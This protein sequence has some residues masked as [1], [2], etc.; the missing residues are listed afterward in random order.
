MLDNKDPHEFLAEAETASQCKVG[1]QNGWELQDR[2]ALE[3][4]E[5]STS[6][7]ATYF[8]QQRLSHPI[9]F[10]SPKIF[11]QPRLSQGTTDHRPNHGY[12]V[13][14]PESKMYANDLDSLQ[15][16][17]H[18]GGWFSSKNKGYQHITHMKSQ[19]S[20]G[21]TK[22]KTSASGSLPFNYRNQQTVENLERPIGHFRLNK[23][24]KQSAMLINVSKVPKPAAKSIITQTLKVQDKDFIT[25]CL[26]LNNSAFLRSS[27]ENKARKIELYQ[28]V[29]TRPSN[30]PKIE[31]SLKKSPKASP[32]ASSSNRFSFPA[33]STPGCLEG[34]QTS[35]GAA[36]VID[37]FI[38]ELKK[39]TRSGVRNPLAH[40]VEGR[41]GPFIEITPKPHK[42]RKIGKQ[43]DTT[44]LENCQQIT[45]ASYSP[46]R[47][48]TD[49]DQLNG[50]FQRN[51]NTSAKLPS[52]SHNLGSK[53]TEKEVRIDLICSGTDIVTRSFD[54]STK[55]QQN[56]TVLSVK[57]LIDGGSTGLDSS[58]NLDIRNPPELETKNHK[59]SSRFD[60]RSL[61]LKLDGL[62]KHTQ[63]L[64]TSNMRSIFKQPDPPNNNLD[65][66]KT[67]NTGDLKVLDT[68]S[69]VAGGKGYENSEAHRSSQ[70][71]MRVKA[72]EIGNK[73]SQKHLAASRMGN[74]FNIMKMASRKFATGHPNVLP[75]TIG[76]EGKSFQPELRHRRHDRIEELDVRA[77]QSSEI[78]AAL[79]RSFEP[80]PTSKPTSRLIK[81][82]FPAP[83]FVL[84]NPRTESE[85][86]KPSSR[87]H[88]GY[89]RTRRLAEI[90]SENL[91]IAGAVSQMPTMNPA[92]KTSEAV[93]TSQTGWQSSKQKSVHLANFS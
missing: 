80:S 92:Q 11:E 24:P 81:S 73:I 43:T 71:G 77:G 1:C 51:R 17:N 60:M 21:C 78:T 52:L 15:D 46:A 87:N 55:P 37:D 86:V 3:L 2:A 7:D 12:F 74:N 53:S 59:G 66:Q 19:K 65:V 40:G 89:L 38:S 4:L 16:V 33:T 41:R 36:L 32:R 85:G 48:I 69:T 50:A 29:L 76:T 88:G 91:R 44:Q 20:G 49:L 63:L 82:R 57:H 8:E 14:Q 9:N 6:Q 30:S 83:Q 72:S 25:S 34:S 23:R 13:K 45:E 28:A 26:D 62:L 42:A 84:L 22:P 79:F 35:N 61:N 54:A 47:K 31:G 70:A 27:I 75:L 90:L 5:M 39:L 18:M 68:T 93:P 10:S 56:P 67:A 64:K 58:M